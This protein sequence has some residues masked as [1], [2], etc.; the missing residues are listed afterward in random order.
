MT[1]IVNYFRSFPGRKYIYFNIMPFFQIEGKVKD[2]KKWEV[3]EP[4]LIVKERNS[5]VLVKSEDFSQEYLGNNFIETL[6][7]INRDRVNLVLEMF[8]G[9]DPKKIFDLINTYDGDV[10]KVIWIL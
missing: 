2:V 4:E 9:N 7:D 3:V 1:K 10:D 6:D 8:P 5:N